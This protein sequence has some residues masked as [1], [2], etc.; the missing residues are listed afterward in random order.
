MTLF[1]VCLVVASTQVGNA[2]CVAVFPRT[3]RDWR[4]FLWQAAIV[5]VLAALAGAMGGQ[6]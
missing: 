5:A 6:R 4:Y 1:D 2:L 3:C